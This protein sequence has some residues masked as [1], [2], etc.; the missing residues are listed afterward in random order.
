MFD[1]EWVARMT[2]DELDQLLAQRFNLQRSDL[3]AALKTLPAIKPGAAA[4]TEDEARLL[5]EAGFV[6]DPDAFVEAAADI[7]AHT[8]L[9]INTAYTGP[10]VAAL[11]GLNDSRIRQRRLA[12]TLWAIDDNG[13]WV[14]PTI[15]FEP[16]LKTG[17][18]DK[19]IRGLEQVF[20]ALLPT[21]RHP[22]AVAGLLRSPQT[23]L[24]V[25]GRP[26]SV[27]EWLRSGGPVDP[28]LQLIEIADWA[29]A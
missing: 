28:V 17:K 16:N 7:V 26:L 2:V 5:D 6:E 4:L 21:G 15:Q 22:T 9:L 11:L 1:V 14:Y 18:P 10:E 8:A 24:E 23:E 13:T 27:L 12:H 20:Q 19:Q 3:L 25:D 29:S